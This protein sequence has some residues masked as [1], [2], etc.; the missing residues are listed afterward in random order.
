[1]KLAVTTWYHYRNFG[2]ALQAAALSAVLRNMGHAPQMIQYKPCGYFRTLPDYSVAALGRRL[3]RKMQN[4][5]PEQ[6]EARFCDELRDSLFEDFLNENLQFTE[7]CTTLADL[8]R[9]NEN[10]DA[11]ICGSD[12]IWSP[13]VF[14]PKYY[15][16]F[17][18]DPKKKIAYAPSIGAEEIEDSYVKSEIKK[19]LSNFGSLSIREEAGQKLIKELTGRDAQVVLDPTLLLTSEQWKEKADI[20]QQDANEPY[21]LVYMLGDNEE[22][23]NA[24]KETAAQ[25]ELPLRL[26]PVFAK[27][28]TREGCIADPVGPKEFLQLFHNASYVCTDSFHGMIFALQFHRPFTAFARF[29]KSDTRNQNSRVLHLLHTV[30]MQN[31]LMSGGNWNIIAKTAPDF[32]S[33]ERILREQRQTS[34]DYLSEALRIAETAKEQSLPVMQQNSLCCGC[35]A[36]RSAC[37]VSA[38]SITQNEKG[39]WEATVDETKCIRCGKCKEV[40]PFCTETRSVAAKKA[41]LY[42]FKSMDPQVLLRSTSGGAA[43]SIAN[44]LLWQGYAVAGCRYNV[45]KQQA[46]HVLIQSQEEL[47]SLQGSKY[48]QS[49]F[50]QVI[51][52]LHA[53]AKPLAIFGT[54]CQIAGAR[55]ALGKRTDVIYIDLVCHGVPSSHLYKKYREHIE[56]T[57]GING[58]EMKMTF[59]YKPKGWR[60]IYL[61]ADDGKN[62]YCCGKETDPFFRMFEVGNCYNETC[63]ECRWRVDSEAD[64]RLGD[65]WGPKFQA[66]STGV[67]MVIVF[68]K[69]GQKVVDW[70]R[71]ANVASMEKQPIDDYLT[72]QQSLN[73]PKPIFYEELFASLKNPVRKLTE[74]VDKYAVP[75]ENKNLTRKEHLRYIIKMLFLRGMT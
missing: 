19:L 6:I 44:L 55:R 27:D 10:F 32:L 11:F 3:Y 56:K 7:A 39:F 23:W 45:E 41:A 38:I 66:D 28:L 72:Y 13:L 73:L 63:Y 74:L 42:S 16:D 4:P 15:L 36:C 33:A 68:T 50:A 18:H 53:C 20:K 62:E 21:L 57:S 52:E 54:P 60:N 43:H 46:E 61:H 71:A 47:T 25:L 59:R 70:L 22:H 2:T 24:A 35:G 69:T 67:N 9:L 8:E 37:P 40:C 64:I 51:D 17:V 1:M 5:K 14:N 29:H 65:Y 31:R 26:I 49:N 34:L 58:Q 12:Q 30:G 75:L 48:I